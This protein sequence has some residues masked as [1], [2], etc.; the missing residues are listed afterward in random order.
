MQFLNKQYRENLP[1]QN[2]H[3]FLTIQEARL[4]LHCSTQELYL[5]IKGGKIPAFKL[6]RKYLLKQS[7]LETFISSNRYIPVS[8]QIDV[9]KKDINAEFARVDAIRGNYAE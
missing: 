1:N 2:P 7:D 8:A 9:T 5:L 6:Q 3:Q 4:Y